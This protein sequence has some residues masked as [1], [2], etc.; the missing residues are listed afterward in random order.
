MIKGKTSSGLEFEINEAV[1]HD[2]RVPFLLADIQDSKIPEEQLKNVKDLIKILFG[3]M[4]GAMAFMSAVADLHS[5]ICAPA[6]A[7]TEIKEILGAIGKNS[8]AS[9]RMSSEE[10]QK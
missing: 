1:I 4:R 7:M 10:E 8:S 6:D 2:M 5:G 3:G 9:P